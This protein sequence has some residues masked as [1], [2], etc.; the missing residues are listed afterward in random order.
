MPMT[1]YIILLAVI[2]VLLLG[3]TWVLN[4]A[5]HPKVAEVAPARALEASDVALASWTR[6]S[7]AQGLTPER[8][9]AL[10]LLL[11]SE[12]TE[13][14]AS[15]LA[16]KGTG[17]ALAPV[18]DARRAAGGRVWRGTL[19]IAAPSPHAVE[20]QLDCRH[21]GD[22][23]SIDAS[24]LPQIAASASGGTPERGAA[25]IVNPPNAVALTLERN[26]QNDPPTWDSLRDGRRTFTLSNEE[27]ALLRASVQRLLE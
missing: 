16:V 26:R 9:L 23:F 24:V 13:R 21:D 25:L 12:Q 2:I 19:E 11:G 8:M 17:L 5:T 15:A 18:A 27:A 22:A 4:R 7:L 14:S 1:V 10:L 20:I 3:S 6:D